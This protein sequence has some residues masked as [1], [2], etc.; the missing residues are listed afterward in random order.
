VERVSVPAVVTVPASNFINVRTADTAPLEETEP[1]STFD[2]AFTSDAPGDS[3]AASPLRVLLINA[4]AVVAAPDKILDTT[5][6]N[7]PADVTVP[8]ITFSADLVID[9]LVVTVPV[10][11]LPAMRASAPLDVI[12]PD[13]ERPNCL[14]N[15]P[16]VV[17]A[18]LNSLDVDFRIIAVSVNAPAIAFPAL[19]TNAPLDDNEP[20]TTFDVRIVADPPVAMEPDNER[21]TSLNPD[22]VADDAIEPDNERSIFLSS[23]PL[24][25]TVPDN[26]REIDLIN[27][28]A[29]VIPHVFVDAVLFVGAPDGVMPPV[30]AVDVCFTGAPDGVMPPYK[31]SKFAPIAPTE[32][33]HAN[34][35]DGSASSM[36]SVKPSLSI[37]CTSIKPSTAEAVEIFT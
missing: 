26:A 13:I 28:L 1:P 7:N 34:A 20:E 2:A 25:V 31:D 21:I 11:D 35:C 29:G 10:T 23:A 18:P 16:L 4:P 15:K 32:K 9:A 5:L 3:D 19:R 27:P 12:P 30:L 14:R 36:I 17:I 37:D 24:V 33:Y 6:C 22:N 8:P